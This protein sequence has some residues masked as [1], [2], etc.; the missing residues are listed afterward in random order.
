MFALVAAMALTACSSSDNSSSSSAAASSAPAATDAAATQAPAAG[1]DG[2]Q[3]Y[4][5]N[6]SSCHQAN[7][8][9][10]AGAFPPLAGN[11]TV[12]GDPKKVIH[13]VKY[14]LTGSITVA[15]K[16]FNGTMPPWQTLPDAQIAS[17]ITYI[18][19]SWGNSASAV[20]AADVSSVKR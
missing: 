11:A 14:G 7:G 9:G 12:T 17:V 10:V 16:T 20:S 3:A 5:A 4:S 1:G 18:R 8:Q 6:C 15:G 13:I 2:A 19:S